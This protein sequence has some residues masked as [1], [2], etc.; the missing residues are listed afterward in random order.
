MA[1]LSYYKIV[2][3]QSRTTLTSDNAFTYN[4]GT[5]Y[6]NYSWYNRVVYGSANRLSRYREYDMMDADTDVS[7]AL[8]MITEEVAGNNPKLNTPL[9]IQ[10]V[11]EHEQYVESSVVVTLK[12]A[13]RTW[14]KLQEFQ[15]RLFQAIRLV[16]KYGDCPFIRPSD[17]NKKFIFLHPKDLLGARVA[18]N[19]PTDVVSWLL[20]HNQFD[21]G[22]STGS[23][24]GYSPVGNN[25][26]LNQFSAQELPYDSIIR[27]SLNNDLSE[28]APFGESILRSIYKTFKQKELLEDSLI[29]YRVTRAPE[30][31]VFYIDVGKTPPNLV[32]T[33]LNKIKDEI[34]QKKIP[35]ENGG[36]SSVESI[37]NP[38][39]MQE[40]YFMPT[41]PDGGGNRVE[42]LPGGQ[43][44]GELQDLEYFYKK[45]WRGLRIPQSYIDATSDGGGIGN[46]GKVGI[47]YIQEIKFSLYIERLQKSIEKTLD[48]E[49]KRFL[50][51][52]SI[53]I[54]PT[55]F[56]VVLP[57]PSNY[58]TSRQQQVDSDILN[59]LGAADGVSYLSKR[60]V[61]MKYGQM[62]MDDVKT[63]ERLMREEKGLPVNGG[64]LDLPA[65][66][67]PTDAELGGFDGGFGGLRQSSTPTP[68]GNFEQNIDDGDQVIKDEVV[69]TEQ[70]DNENEI[71][72]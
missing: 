46:D 49:F 45:I 8:D 12:A 10:I 50:K 4:D 15:T 48:L 32:A 14:C 18:T 37:Y 62:S 70:P 11:S 9:N 23:V 51:E 44:L 47:A 61:M 72:K 33:Q 63:N 54:D 71:I 53:D 7:R 17:K 36:T 34:K 25:I 67:Q 41:K 57:E 6:N 22:V 19:D 5:G 60:F 24:G 30:R 2:S 29:I 1:L 3:P 28:E 52:N 13:L 66:Y 27:F 43:N 21:L 39:S 64:N 20:R 69:Q 31:R 56:N 35:S 65:I 38:H 26:N 68:P 40:D 55:I 42:V 58:R 16:L 59:N